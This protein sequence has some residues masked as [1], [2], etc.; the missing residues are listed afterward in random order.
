MISNAL[1]IMRLLNEIITRDVFDDFEL[2]SMFIT[3]APQEVY[4]VHQESPRCV[5]E[6]YFQVQS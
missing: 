3:Q 4:C 2:K 1:T 5:G 6:H